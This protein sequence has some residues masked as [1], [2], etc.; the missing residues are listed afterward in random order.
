MEESRLHLE[1]LMKKKTKLAQI[2]KLLIE[3]LLGSLGDSL[4][5]IL[6]AI[7]RRQCVVVRERL[8]AVALMR[9]TLKMVQNEKNGKFQWKSLFKSV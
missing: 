7:H 5:V 6:G 8:S 1:R 4:W 3:Q 2:I 9:H